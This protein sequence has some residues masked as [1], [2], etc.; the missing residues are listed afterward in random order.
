MSDTH[1]LP[2]ALTSKDVGQI[3]FAKGDG[4]VPCVVQ[5]AD[6]LQVLMLG[7]MDKDALLET[8]SLGEVVF[9]SRSK[10]RLWRKGETSG[11]VLK[12]DHI[13]T[14]CDEDALLVM[15][16]PQGPTCHTKTTSCFGIETAPGI[17]FLGHLAEV[18]HER[19]SAPPADSYTAR[20]MTKG[21]AKIAQKVGEEGLETAL[22]GRAGDLEELHNESADLLYHLTVLLMARGT[23]L[24]PILDILRERHEA[25]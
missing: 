2:A 19:A 16:R 14:D 5:H 24:G 22:A 3:D 9:Y 4:L 23:S 18:V 10:K 20:L 7:Y 12:L 17:G 15:A 13:L 25:R 1:K 6:T 8:F 21:V 11:D